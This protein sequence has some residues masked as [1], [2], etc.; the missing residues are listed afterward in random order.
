MKRAAALLQ[1]DNMDAFDQEMGSCNQLMKTIDETDATADK[2]KQQILDT[3]CYPE[4]ARLENGIAQIVGA[5]EQV[6]KDCNN[7]AELKLKTYG[8]QIKDIRSTRRGIDGYASQFQK[9]DAVF[10]DAK[11]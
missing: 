9:R 5:L 6:R 2:L 8:Q 3:R 10:I 7:I 11:K 1:D 4:I